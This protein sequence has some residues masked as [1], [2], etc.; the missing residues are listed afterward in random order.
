MFILVSW[1][2]PNLEFDLCFPILSLIGSLISLYRSLDTFS[3]PSLNYVCFSFF[4]EISWDYEILLISFDFEPFRGLKF[5]SF[6]L[7]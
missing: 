2:F 5:L 3:F 4:S 7:A 1:T 6:L